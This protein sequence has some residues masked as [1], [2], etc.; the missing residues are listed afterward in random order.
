MRSVIEPGFW[1][2]RMRILPDD[3]IVDQMFDYCFPILDKIGFKLD[4]LEDAI[5]EGESRELVRRLR[6]AGLRLSPAERRR[7]TA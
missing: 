1:L 7:R 4:T 3:I 2:D 5:F 6:A